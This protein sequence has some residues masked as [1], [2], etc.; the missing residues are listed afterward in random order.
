[1]LPSI[2]RRRSALCA[3]ASLVGLLASGSLAAPALAQSAS[4]D[5]EIIVTATRRAESIQDIPFNIAAVGAAQI[6]EQGFGDIAQLIEFV[7][8][9]NIVDQGG[10]DGN[11]IVVRGLN[12]DPISGGGGGAGSDGGGTVSPYIGEIPLFVDLR[13]N[14]LERVE[15]LLGPQGTLYGAGT[16][17]GAIRYIPKR[18]QFDDYSVEARADAYSYKEGDGISTDIG[19]TVNVP[20]GERL[21]LRGNVDVLDDKG[22]ID[23][24]FVSRLP[25]FFNPDPDFTNQADVDANLLRVEDANYEKVQTYRLGL[26]AQPTDWLDVNLTYYG[27]VAKNG[28]RTTSG[29]RGPV[30]AGEYEAPLR[31]VEPAK[32]DTEL[33]AVEVTADLGFAELTSATGISEENFYGQRDQTDLLISLEYSYETFPTFT[34]FTLE[35]EK[36]ER[37]NQ[38]LRLVSQNEGPLDWI[39]GYFYNQANNVGI[40]SEFTPGFGDFAFG[41]GTSAQLN[42]LEYYAVGRSELV[43]QAVFG[44]IGYQL[45]DRWDVTGGIRV[46][47]YTLDTADAFPD[48]VNPQTTVFFPYFGCPS[49]Q[50]GLSLEAA[51]RDSTYPL[52][53]NQEFSGEL[54]KLNTSYEVSDAATLYATFSQGYRIGASNGLAPC[55]DVFVPGPQGQCGLTPGQ[56]FGPNAGDIAQINERE[57]FPD[58]VD[59][60]EIGA[61]TQWL[62]GDLTLNVVAYFIDWKDPQ[63]ASASVNANLPITVNAGAAES[64][65]LEVL[66]SWAVTDRFNLRGNYSYVD[67]ELSEA[68]PSLVR[69]ITPPGFGTA[70]EDG[71]VGDRLPGSPKHQFSVFGDYEQP[72]WNGDWFANAALTYQSS[73]LSRTGGRGSSL[74]LPSY[75]RVNVATGYGEDN[76][77]LTVYVDNLFDD[78]SETSVTGTSLSSQ[79]P[80]GL[81]VRSFRTNVLPPRSVGARLRITY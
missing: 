61:K 59:N 49:G 62:D 30:P 43:E 5:D 37:I 29:L 76:W 78:Y 42:D 51:D 36:S 14:D 13:L 33:W 74:T 55:P 73:V 52:G 15:V 41:P 69:T 39:V 56:Q 27:Q 11:R 31:V 60:F 48:P 2:T 9:I 77:R 26:R 22:F 1:M 54:F 70:F 46:Y 45:T 79:A 75:A 47:N 65:G 34:G 21:A 68:V 6:E 40:S 57:F 35:E 19:F 80:S 66:G 3:S 63:V 28:G 50:C 38:E 67:S 64:K 24:P 32:L 53:L 23:Y 25:G 12:A 10:R 58:T 20:L 44:E 71:Q 17:G 7:P 72:F 18:P 16:M 8:G 4:A 81:T